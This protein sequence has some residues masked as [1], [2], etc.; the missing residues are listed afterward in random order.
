MYVKTPIRLLRIVVVIII[1]IIN[2]C[3]LLSQ[4][5]QL[6]WCYGFDLILLFFVLYLCRNCLFLYLDN[7]S[8]PKIGSAL[9]S[10]DVIN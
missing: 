3:F 5:S 8:G 6:F 2:F 10:L 7:R 9:L 4:Y 1:I